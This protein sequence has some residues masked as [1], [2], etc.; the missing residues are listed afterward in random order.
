MSTEDEYKNLMEAIRILL[1]TTEDLKTVIAP[2]SEGHK[3][4]LE[5]Q[6]KQQEAIESLME[7]LLGTR[8]EHSKRI[9]ELDLKIETMQTL[10]DHIDERLDKIESEPI[11]R[12]FQRIMREQTST[13]DLNALESAILRKPNDDILLGLKSQSLYLLNR[14]KESRSFLEESLS[15]HLKSS[16]LWF[17]KGLILDSGTNPEKLDEQIKCFDKAIE[18]SNSSQQHQIYHAQ[19]VA[20]GRARRFKDSLDCATKV[21]ETNPKCPSG[22][23]LKGLSFLNLHQVPEALGC[24][25]KALELDPD[26]VNALFQKGVALSVLGKQN[27]SIAIECYDKVIG[28]EPKFAKAYFNKGRLLMDDDL[29]KEALEALDKGLEIVEKNACAWCM[30]GWALG[31]LGRKKEEFESYERALKLE[32][33]NGCYIILNNYAYSLYQSKKY[34]KGIEISNKTVEIEPDNPVFLDTLACNLQGLR[35]DKE[36]LAVFEKALKL[37]KEDAQI[38]W[39]VLAKLYRRMGKEEAEQAYKKYKSLKEK[40]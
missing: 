7:K 26:N 6:E 8:E 28:I 19:T 16:F 3:H 32:P 11:H 10:F 20:L 38:S 34:K 5:A 25:E 15:K 36:A 23:T 4:V 29:P 37:K 1:R 30:R 24:F 2:L 35:K 13:D 21:I 14:K 33:I 31:K 40:S 12:I 27:N 18:L 17:T 22:W 39:D 9:Q